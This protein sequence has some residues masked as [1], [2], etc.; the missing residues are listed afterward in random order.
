MHSH[1]VS[2]APESTEI[3]ILSTCSD[4]CLL[5]AV[6]GPVSPGHEYALRAAIV[7]VYACRDPAYRAASASLPLSALPM[8]PP[9]A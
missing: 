9:S 7:L 4:A 8:R 5:F 6:I 1:R 3:L 2:F